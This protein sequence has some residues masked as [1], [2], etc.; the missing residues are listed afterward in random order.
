MVDRELQ[1][2]KLFFGVQGNPAQDGAVQESM[3]P[4]YDRTKEHLG[5]AD[6]MIIRVRRRLLEAVKAFRD[7]G[8]LPP[9]V[10]NPAMY[11][12][13]PV[14]AVL[15]KGADWVQTTAERRKAWY[16]TAKA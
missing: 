7:R 9:G 15:P 10:H 3:G 1:K 8:E 16:A 13:R 12:I 5:T 6:A 2:T 14:G 11:R 4:I